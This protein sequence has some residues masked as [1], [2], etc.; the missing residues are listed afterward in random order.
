[1]LKKIL[2]TSLFGVLALGLTGCVQATPK[3]ISSLSE[4]EQ[5]QA[6]QEH[7][8]LAKYIQHPSEKVQLA[9]V[10]K[11]Y[12][13]V[14][15]LKNPSLQVQLAA[16]K[17]NPDALC[18]IQA[19]KR[20]DKAAIVAIKKANKRLQCIDNTSSQKVQLAAINKNILY[21]TS[22]HKPSVAVQLLAVKKDANSLLYIREPSIEAQLASINKKYHKKLSPQNTKALARLELEEAQRYDTKAQ[23]PYIKPSRKT[24]LYKNAYYFYRLSAQNNYN[25]A[26][27][28][29]AQYYSKGHGVKQNYLTS[30][31]YYEKAATGKH[32]I[33]EAKDNA[34][35]MYFKASQNGNKDAQ[36][37]INHLCK[38]NS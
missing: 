15:N 23:S 22:L 20:L 38:N 30:A 4:D 18:S 9:L 26:N 33:S 6:L 1:M 7:T 21:L 36:I 29:L 24:Q 35:D 12:T 19:N 13:L 5:I 2:Y 27:Y 11:D 16:I 34:C 3:N 28:M 31:Q 37:K 25:E 32:A 8:E 14:H 10:Q 17:K